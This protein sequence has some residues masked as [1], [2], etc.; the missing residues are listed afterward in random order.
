MVQIK[1]VKCALVFI[2]TNTTGCIL[3]QDQQDSLETKRLDVIV[4]K[5]QK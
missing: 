4:V 5:A 3:A 2:L 1:L